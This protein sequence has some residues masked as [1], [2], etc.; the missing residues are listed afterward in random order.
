MSEEESDSGTEN[1]MDYAGVAEAIEIVSMEYDEEAVESEQGDVLDGRDVRISDLTALVVSL[2]AQC[3]DTLRD[4]T[5]A[6]NA[7]SELRV[8]LVEEQ[9][10]SRHRQEN[11]RES[12]IRL[13]QLGKLNAELTERL[14]AEALGTVC[15]VVSH[16][17]LIEDNLVRK[18]KCELQTEAVRE[19][20]AK[21]VLLSENSGERK[22][23]RRESGR[24]ASHV[25]YLSAT[26]EETPL[27]DT[28]GDDVNHEEDYDVIPGSEAIIPGGIRAKK[29]ASSFGFNHENGYS[30]IMK[31]KR[32]E[33]KAM[34]EAADSET[35][36]Q[37]DEMNIQ[38]LL[39]QAGVIMHTNDNLELLEVPSQE[40]MTSE[41]FGVLIENLRS[42]R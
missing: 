13:L 21:C 38:K 9:G 34:S 10:C 42:C 31:A 41:W 22:A 6:E 20:E 40:E 27:G 37:D 39:K 7:E 19:L 26:Q 2:R 25:T 15:N 18:A 4:R 16:D 33:Y 5:S 35:S 36:Y 30:L 17:T 12:E 1:A 29:G 14:A 24:L 23:R 32:A 8:Q 3:T 28:D 11:L